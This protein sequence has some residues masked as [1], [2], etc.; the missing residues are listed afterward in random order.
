MNEQAGWDG[1][2]IT[3]TVVQKEREKKGCQGGLSLGQEWGP[4]PLEI[5]DTFDFPRQLT[6]VE[7]KGSGQSRAKQADE[8]DPGDSG[9]SPYGSRSRSLS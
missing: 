9:G 4:F 6:E 2:T 1:W 5:L 8:R 3:Y 7:E